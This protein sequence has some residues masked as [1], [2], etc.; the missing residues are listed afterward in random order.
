MPMTSPTS[1]LPLGDRDEEDA[2]F[3]LFLLVSI[4]GT[5]LKEEV[6]SDIFARLPGITTLLVHSFHPVPEEITHLVENPT[7]SAKMLSHICLES[8]SKISIKLNFFLNF[9]YIC[10]FPF[11]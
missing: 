2:L 6:F 11:P 9:A 5:L 7:P 1:A 3:N 4:H 8:S 10:D